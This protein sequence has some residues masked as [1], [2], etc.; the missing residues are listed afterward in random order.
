MIRSEIE[1]FLNINKD[2][3]CQNCHKRKA[4][5][6]WVGEG[7]VLD[8]AHGAYQRWCDY[9]SVEAQLKYAKKQ[10]KQIPVLERRMERL[11]KK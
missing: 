7:G 1:A 10:A 5:T 3:L 4:T 8:F 9:C 6:N 2:A 11:K